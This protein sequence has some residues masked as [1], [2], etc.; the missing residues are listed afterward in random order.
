[1][2]TTHSDHSGSDSHAEINDTKQ[3]D[4]KSTHVRFVL[5]GMAYATDKINVMISIAGYR[6]GVSASLLRCLSV[7]LCASLSL[8]HSQAASLLLYLS[9]PLPSCLSVSL[10]LPPCAVCM[11]L[12]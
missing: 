6:M 9:A 1:M 4:E 5:T 12:Y 3:N 8:C 10:R 2:S 11:S 7:P